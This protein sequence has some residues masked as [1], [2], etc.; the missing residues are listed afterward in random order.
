MG[1]TKSELIEMWKRPPER[2]YEIAKTKILQ[3]ILETEGNLIVSFSGGKDSSLLLD[4]YCEIISKTQ[5]NDKPI[6]VIFANTTNET[7]EMR[8]FIKSFIPRCEEKYDVKI[9]FSEVKPSVVWANYVRDNGIPLI[10]KMQAKAIRSIK[11]DM[12]K[13]GCDFDYIQRL[14]RQE[15]SAVLELEEIGFSKTGILSLTGWVSKRGCFGQKFRISKKWLPMVNCDIDL[16]EQ[17]CVNIKEKPLKSIPDANYM[18]GEQAAESEQRTADYLKTGC[19]T[20]LPN[21]LYKSKPFGAMTTDGILYSLKYR[22]VPI[23]GDYGDIVID[24]DGHYRCTKSQRT[25]CALCG[26][27]CQYDVERFVRLQESEPAKVKFAFT[28]KSEG[29]AGYGEAIQ[30]MNEYCGT[31]VLI[32]DIK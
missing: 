17:C 18:T 23:C 21:G 26:F 31:K 20:V 1:Y 16:T 3:A 6:R 25:G 11:A 24:K 9:S 27:G 22:G 2:Q 28:P 8:R 14:Y 32:P 10:S 13:T 15:R 12:I 5:Y 4:M 7:A 19:N 29:G 30:Y